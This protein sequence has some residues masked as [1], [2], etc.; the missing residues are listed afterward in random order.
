MIAYGVY[1]FKNRGTMSASVYIMQYRVKAQSVVV[2]AM[3]IGVAY[4]MLR[5]H[6]F[7]KPPSEKH[8][9]S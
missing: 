5:D 9:S 1:D 2:G 8:S 4:A 6:V 3:T 7:N